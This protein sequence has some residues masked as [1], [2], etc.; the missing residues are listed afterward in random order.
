MAVTDAS[1]QRHIGPPIKF[2]NEPARPR[3]AVPDYPGR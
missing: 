1:G 3:W 2:L